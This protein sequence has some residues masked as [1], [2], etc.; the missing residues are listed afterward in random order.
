M[1]LSHA[2]DFITRGMK[3]AAFRRVLNQANSA[4]ELRSVLEQQRLSFTATEFDDAFSH[5]LTLCQFEEQANVLQEFKMWWEMIGGMARY[6]EHS[7]P[8]G[9]NHDIE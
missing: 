1:S 2:H 6:A 7:R 5:L 3:D 8:A 4:D 9:E